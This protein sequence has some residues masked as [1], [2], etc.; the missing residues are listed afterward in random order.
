MTDTTLVDGVL[1]TDRLGRVKTP[2]ERREALLDEFERG[3]M[4][5]QAFARHY[6][7]KYQTLASWIQKRRRG[8]GESEPGAGGLRLV[9][10]V[11]ESGKVVPEGAKI[12]VRVELPGG[13]SMEVSNGWQAALAAQL[14]RALTQPLKPC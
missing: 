7:I 1:K 10:A 12:A 11:I 2:V 6:G 3:G 13:A 5:G 9:E 14:L 4:S 8:R